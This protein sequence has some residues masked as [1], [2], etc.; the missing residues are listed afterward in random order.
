MER[1]RLASG[2]SVTEFGS[3]N[4]EPQEPLSPVAGRIVADEFA[5]AAAEVLQ[6]PTLIAESA[7]DLEANDDP[8]TLEQLRHIQKL[9]AAVQAEFQPLGTIG[10]EVELVFEAPHPFEE[11]FEEEEVIADRYAA[12]IQVRAKPAQWSW[13][14]R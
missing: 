3:L 6:Q 10:P 4:D 7:A 12:M 14:W 8:Q 2:D 5:G 1:G 9:L 13:R 11:P